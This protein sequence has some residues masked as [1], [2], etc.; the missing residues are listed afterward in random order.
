MAS[1]KSSQSD[2]GSTGDVFSTFLDTVRGDATDETLSNAAQLA[3][4]RL[5]KVFGPQK[6]EKLQAMASSDPSKFFNALYQLAEEKLIEISHDLDPNEA[7]VKMTQAG[8]AF[9]NEHK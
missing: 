1:N 7:E 9:L 2:K 3:L 5:L 6:L 4:L 8:E